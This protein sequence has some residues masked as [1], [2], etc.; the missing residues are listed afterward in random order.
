MRQPKLLLTKQSLTRYEMLHILFLALPIRNGIPQS[1]L[2]YLFYI[3]FVKPL[4]FPAIGYWQMLGL[5][6]FV[7]IMRFQPLRKL[8]PDALDENEVD[9]KESIELYEHSYSN[10]VCQLLLGWVV[11]MLIKGH[12]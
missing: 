10:L 2:V 11:H 7:R 1:L 5:L 3:W 9:Y 4:G 8:E 12:L 6:A